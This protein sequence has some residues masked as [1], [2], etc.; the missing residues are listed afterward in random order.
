MTSE[1]ANKETKIQTG[2]KV[3]GK[4]KKTDNRQTDR[5]TDR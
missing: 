1:K 5:Q 4:K 2:G 3:D